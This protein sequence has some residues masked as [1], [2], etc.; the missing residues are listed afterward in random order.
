[1]TVAR[2]VLVAVDEAKDEAHSAV[3]EVVGDRGD[4]AYDELVST[5][6][7]RLDRAVTNA[8]SRSFLAAACLALLSLVP[9]LLGRRD[10]TV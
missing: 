4:P 3:D 1:M 9:I 10:L 7:D 6:Q 8:F 5:L 2:R